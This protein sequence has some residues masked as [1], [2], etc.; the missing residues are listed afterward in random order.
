VRDGRLFIREN[1]EPE[2]EYLA[3]SPSDFYSATSTDECSF[4]PA[5][6]Q[7]QVMVLHLDDGRNLE[8]KRVP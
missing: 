5:T 6:G 1:D 2:Q 7:G 4:R 8:L 3:E